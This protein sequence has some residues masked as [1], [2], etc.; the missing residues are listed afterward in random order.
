MITREDIKNL[1]DLARLEIEDSEAESL[2]K[3]VDSILGY[4]SQIETM[5]TSDK[6]EIPVL[7][8]VMREDSVTHQPGQYTEDLLSN[9]PA[10]EKNLLK[11][12]KI[13]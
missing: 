5:P 2:T 9:A 10:R 1:A 3:E 8:N 12:K 7:R 6:S 11:V 13:L 4:V